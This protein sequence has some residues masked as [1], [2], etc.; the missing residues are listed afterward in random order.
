MEPVPRGA[1]GPA[2][3][4][5]IAWVLPS[6][7]LVYSAKAVALPP[8]SL[9]AIQESGLLMD[10]PEKDADRAAYRRQMTSVTRNMKIDRGNSSAGTLFLWPGQDAAGIPGSVPAADG[11]PSILISG[12]DVSLDRAII[13]FVTAEDGWIRASFSWYPSLKATMDGEGT[14]IY[15]SILGA[16]LVPVPAGEH[17]LTLEPGRLDPAPGIAGLF[18][19][20]IALIAAIRLRP[21]R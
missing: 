2:S 11:E 20:L 4:P 8:D 13:R 3:D 14:R 21:A 16:C 19:G 18:A 10:L 5:P 7:P 9:T 15:R 1:P 12:Y 17:T 6:S